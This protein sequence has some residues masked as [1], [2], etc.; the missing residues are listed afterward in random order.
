M[1]SVQAEVTYDNEQFNAFV[2]LFNRR[3]N[4]VSFMEG[5]LDIKEMLSITMSSILKNNKDL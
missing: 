5:L 1:K 2:D 3:A 4:L